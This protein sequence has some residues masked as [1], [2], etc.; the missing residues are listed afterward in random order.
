MKY[1]DGL[2]YLD[3]LKEFVQ[4]LVISRQND[5][6]SDTNTEDVNDYHPLEIEYPLTIGKVV[7]G[8]DECE[9][10]VKEGSVFFLAH[11]RN[12]AIRKRLGVFFGS[13]RGSRYR[14]F[15]KLA[16]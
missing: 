6:D 11:A 16:Y 1:V 15:L 9:M 5:D 13:N 7:G 14:L 12:N 3:Q 8:V 10:A 2:N 4:T